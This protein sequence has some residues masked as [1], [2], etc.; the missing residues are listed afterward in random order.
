MEQ[1]VQS[2]ISGIVVGSIYAL[3]ALGFVLIYKSTAVINFAQGELLM[4]GAYICL[5]LVTTMKLPFLLSFVV[6]LLAAAML[7]FLLERLFLRPMIGEPIISVIMLTIGLASL[8]QG[9]IHVI[10]GSDTM[11]FPAIFSPEPVRFLGI[12][13]SQV[14]IYSV[15]AAI[16]CLVL[17]NLY[18]RFSSS[19]IAMRAVANDQ[20]AA[21]A[22]GISISKIFAIA[23][24]IAAIVAGI[25]G[26]LIGNINGVNTSLSSFGLKVFPAV[27]LGGL[28]SIPGAILGGFIIGLLEAL[29]GIYLDPIFEG[30]TKEVMPFIV[31]VIILMIKPYGLFGTEEIEKI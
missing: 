28:D 3:V 19:G 22:M 5:T 27:I 16:I 11:V 24:A 12:A 18:F 29:S 10:W 9:F 25:G 23:W 14:Y 26:I 21:Q 13:I 20:Q 17:F 2:L 6:T 15:L 1:V 4:F 30:G 7:G 31:L 8:M